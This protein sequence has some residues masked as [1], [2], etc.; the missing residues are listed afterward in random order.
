MIL[1]ENITL[2][3]IGLLSNVLLPKSDVLQLF[4]D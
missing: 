2:P 1:I 4:G 3:S